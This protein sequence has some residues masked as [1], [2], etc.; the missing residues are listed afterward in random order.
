[1]KPYNIHI[2]F[3]ILFSLIIS[4]C[5]QKKDIRDSML[6]VNIDKVSDNEVPVKMS[7]FIESFEIVKFENNPEVLLGSSIG[8]IAISENYIALLNHPRIMLFSRDG[9]FIRKIGTQGR[10][11]GEWLVVKQLQIDEEKGI[12]LVS[13]SNFSHDILEYSLDGGFIKKIPMAFPKE[14]YSFRILNHDTIVVVGFSFGADD[15]TI[16][17]MQDYKGKLINYY[18]S[19]LINRDPLG[20]E[21]IYKK[22]DNLLISRGDTIF[23]YQYKTNRLIPRTYFY[24]DYSLGPLITYPEETKYGISIGR[25][26]GK[27]SFNGSK[28][29]TVHLETDKYFILGY[30]Y[31]SDNYSLGRNMIFNKTNDSLFIAKYINDFWDDIPFPVSFGKSYNNEYAYFHFTA[32]GFKSFLKEIMNESGLTDNQIE[33]INKIDSG[34]NENDNNILI[35]GKLR[36]P[37]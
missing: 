28:E 26:P 16:V 27:A 13:Q 9:K 22:G 11:P 34:I 10:G 33:K 3:L 37:K 25:R 2:S 5:G 18:P 23:E 21:L 32:F 17:F 15:S 24:T 31:T 29:I 12:L 8:T 30:S 19:G 6:S 1:M 14:E 36:I 4:S 20:R 7:D 35:I